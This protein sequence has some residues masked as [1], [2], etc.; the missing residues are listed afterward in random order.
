MHSD[1][2][3]AAL[4]TELHSVI[5]L[6]LCTIP[7]FNFGTAPHLLFKLSSGESIVHEPVELGSHEVST[8]PRRLQTSDY[9]FSSSPPN[10][11]HIA[12]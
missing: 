12:K 11:S 4:P 3:I 6:T 7:L 2:S 9:F 1:F 8:K 5:G 10:T